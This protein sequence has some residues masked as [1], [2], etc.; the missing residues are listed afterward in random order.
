MFEQPVYEGPK[1]MLSRETHEQR[2]AFSR[3]FLARV[4]SPDVLFDHLPDVYFFVKDG[5]GRFIRVN[6]AFLGLVG[7][8]SEEDV[9]GARDTDFFPASLAESYVRDDR[10][11]VRAGRPIID[12]AELVRNPDGSLD[13][14]FTTK[15]PIFDKDSHAIGVCGI[16]RDIKKMNRHH[17]QL[18]SWAPVLEAMVSH[19]ANPLSMLALASKVGLS[20][21]QFTRQFS[22]RFR[23]TPKAYQRSVRLNAARQLLVTTQL[24]MAEIAAKTGFYDQSHFASQFAKHHGMPPSEYRAQLAQGRAPD[25]PSPAP[26]TPSPSALKA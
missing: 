6:R 25:L 7:A 26:A 1:P 13:W 17:D 21:S 3:A 15:L 24:T 12:K 20:L 2:R 5:E 22:K 9:I 10:E 18:L 16:T 4:G 11:V 8:T 14:F 23:I 19:C